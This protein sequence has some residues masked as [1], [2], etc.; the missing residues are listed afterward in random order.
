MSRGTLLPHFAWVGSFV[1]HG[2]WPW[3][4]TMSFLM[5]LQASGEEKLWGRHEGVLQ[6]VGH[7]IGATPRPETLLCTLVL[8]VLYL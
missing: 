6:K 5:G 2:E 3:N 8:Y 4:W 1:L 7:V